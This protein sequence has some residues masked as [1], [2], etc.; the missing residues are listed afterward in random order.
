[1]NIG[2]HYFETR[3]NKYRFDKKTGKYMC[4]ECKVMLKSGD[5]G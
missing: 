1:M 5:E 4:L 3:H 2:F